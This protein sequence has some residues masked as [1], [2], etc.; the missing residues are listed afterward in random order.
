MAVTLTGPE[1]YFTRQGAII[2][3]F[4][5]IAADYGSDATTGFQAIWSQFVSSDQA[6]V[7]GLPDALTAF[8][9]SALSY[10]SVLKAEGEQQTILQVNR[11][12][13]VIPATVQQA[14]TLLAAQMRTASASINRPTLGAT[15]TPGGSNL[16]D[17]TVAVSTVNRFGDPL[18]MVFAETVTITCTADPGTSYAAS[19]AAVGET[20][21]DA[22][23][24]LWPAGSGAS[25]SLSVTDPAADSLVTDGGFENWTANQPDDWTI[26][27]GAAGTT[28]TEGAGGVRLP[29]AKTAV[30]TSDGS[31]A[32]QLAQEASL[33]VNTVYAA[34]VYA[35]VNTSDGAGVFRIALVNGD[36]GAVMT[37]D[38]GN[39]LSYTRNLS[40]QVTASF[41]CFTAFFSTPRQLPSSVRLQVGYSTAP[42]NGVFLTLDLA[43]LVA[44]TQL[45]SGGPYVAAFAGADR[46]ALNDAYALAVTNSLGSNSFAR[47]SD[48]LLGLRELDVYYPSSGSPTISDTLV[49]H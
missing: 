6:V 16:G 13:D 8:R 49:L 15:V 19:L 20:A 22:N 44:A 25:T 4:N 17:A 30:V 5:R 32:T 2:G 7:Q 28:V 9:N 21:A 41:Q 35:K 29:A 34:C 43:A 11:D 23:S 38:A 14:I 40:A 46:T 36:T 3:E 45:Y 47:G 18:D 31:Q 26:V 12:V 42:A 1:G 24:Y 37:D 39:S 33:S 10:Q 27:N 48:R